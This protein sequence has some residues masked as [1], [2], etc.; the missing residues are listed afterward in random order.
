[1]CE[2]SSTQESESTFFLRVVDAQITFQRAEDG[3]VSGLVLEQGGQRMPGRK[4]N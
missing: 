4:V 3:T 1:V 2:S